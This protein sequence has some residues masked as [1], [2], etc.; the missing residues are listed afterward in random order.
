MSFSVTAR[1]KQKGVIRASGRAFAALDAQ[2]I[3]N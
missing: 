1:K 3:A 2:F